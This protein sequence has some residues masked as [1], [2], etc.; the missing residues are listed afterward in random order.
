MENEV[1]SGTAEIFMSKFLETHMDRMNVKYK[2]VHS[3]M[4]PNKFKEFYKVHILP[5]VFEE[6]T[7]AESLIIEINDDMFVELA[8]PQQ[9]LVAERIWAKVYVDADSGVLK[10]SAE[11]F[12]EFS[13]IV[14]KHGHETIEALKLSIDQVRDKL[15]DEGKL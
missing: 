9:F 15:K 3:A 14:Q 8:E 6:N 12:R 2:I 11:D 13:L 4:K 10:K 5:Q 7:E 1:S